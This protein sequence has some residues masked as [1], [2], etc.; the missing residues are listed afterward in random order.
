V[1]HPNREMVTNQFNPIK[2][3]QQDSSLESSSTLF[4][5]ILKEK[6]GISN[7]SYQENKLY[8]GYAP[9]DGT[10]WIMVITANEAEV[11]SA[12]PAMSKV[13]LTMVSIVLLISIVIIYIVGT[14]IAKPIIKV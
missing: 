9:I 3:V 8:A 12:I 6:T 14:S 5:N 11:L 10:D 2:E 4:Q 1:A 13:I 7:Y